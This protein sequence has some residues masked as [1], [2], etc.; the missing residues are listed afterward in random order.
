MKTDDQI[1]KSQSSST[2][3]YKTESGSPGEK[4]ESGS[5]G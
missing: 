3:D 2:H 4:T 1:S 5:P